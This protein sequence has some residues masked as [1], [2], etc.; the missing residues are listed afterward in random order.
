MVGP[1]RSVNFNLLS[2][3]RCPYDYDFWPMN[4]G[5]LNIILAAWNGFPEN[6]YESCNWFFFP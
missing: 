3:K 1:V 6:C 5:D 4:F 2:F